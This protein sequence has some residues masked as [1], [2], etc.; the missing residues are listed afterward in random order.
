[1]IRTFLRD[2][3]ELAYFCHI[4]VVIS[5]VVGLSNWLLDEP[6]S[7]RIL[8]DFVGSDSTISDFKVEAS[9][10]ESYH[11]FDL[12]FHTPRIPVEA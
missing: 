5:C 8:P 12:F 2:V 3:A 10:N 9:E 11:N 7:A 6:V 4:L 1:M